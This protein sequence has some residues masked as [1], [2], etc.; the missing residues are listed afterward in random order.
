[1]KL[2]GREEEVVRLIAKGL[3]NKLVGVELDISDHT[4]KFHVHNAMKKSGASTRTELVVKFIVEEAF[5]RGFEEA[6]RKTGCV[7]CDNRRR[8]G[9]CV[10]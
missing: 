4:V 6:A 8:M 3:S 9:T 10:A 1:M 5:R 7:A 2:T